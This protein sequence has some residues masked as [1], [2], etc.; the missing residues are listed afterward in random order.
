MYLNNDQIFDV[1]FM[2]YF[3]I[4]SKVNYC[5]VKLLFQLCVCVCVYCETNVFLTVGF[6]QKGL[7]SIGLQCKRKRIWFDRWIFSPTKQA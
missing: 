7:G 6:G 3:I 2:F 4:C 1:N 5:F